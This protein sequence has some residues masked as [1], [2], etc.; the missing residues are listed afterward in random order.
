MALG[1]QKSNGGGD[2][3][4]VF[5]FNAVS[6]DAAIASSTKN[7]KTGEYDKNEKE[8]SFPVKFVFDMPE[9]EVGYMHFA[10]TGPSFAMVKIGQ[11]LPE[12]PSLEHKQGF[13][14]K[15]YNKE[16][17]LCV[18]SNSSKTI[19]EVMD[20]LHDAY[21]AGAAKNVGKLPVVEIK[22]TKKVSV[23]TK[24]GAKNYKQPD[25]SIVSW[26]SRPEALTEKVAEAAKE[27]ETSDDVDEF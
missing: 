12:K 2:F 22:G 21:M 5:K 24:E 10:A 1:L 20:A 8:V 25:W 23:K 13:R 18:F 16:Y 11:P 3:L 19:S 6:G 14:V 26:V 4:P 15:L 7:E 17:G 27:V 9:I